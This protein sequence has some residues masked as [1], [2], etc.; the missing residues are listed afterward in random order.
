MKTAYS[1]KTTPE[2]IAKDIQNQLDGAH[3]KAVVYFASSS[4]DAEAVSRE[5]QSAFK[6]I[7]VFGCTTAGEIVS[8]KMLKHSV[9]AMAFDDETLEQISL[10]VIENVNSKKAV[11]NALGVFE[12]QYG[13]T[14]MELDPEKYVGIILVDGLG[15]SEER[16]IDRIGDLTNVIFIGGSAGDDLQFRQTH[17]FANGKAYPSGALLALLKPGVAFETLKTQSFKVLGSEL[18]ATRVNEAEREVVE[19][20]GK[21]AAVA[22]AETIGVPV[23]DAPRHFMANPVGLVVDGEPYVRSPQQI[24]GDSIVFYCKVKERMRLSILESTDIVK[25]TKEAVAAKKS[26]MGDIGAIINFNCILRT[27]ELEDKGLC[28]TYANI[29]ADVPTIGFSTYGEQ[30]VGHVNQTATMLVFG[31]RS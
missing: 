26:E 6:S 9:V 17:V 12:K 30:W 16:L 7:T 10:S 15:K 21:K 18:R 14:M 5:M 20:N 29:F 27:L 1:V 19:F 23:K 22:Y 11:E 3:T 8:G 31:T 4:F 2:E 24:K 28:E 25:D 13:C